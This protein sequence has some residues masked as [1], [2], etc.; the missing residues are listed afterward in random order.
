MEALKHTPYWGAN[1]RRDS[2]SG[3]STSSQPVG[4]RYNLGM[5]SPAPT[6]HSQGI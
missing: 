4:M 2:I 3:L 6:Y 1:H 5:Q